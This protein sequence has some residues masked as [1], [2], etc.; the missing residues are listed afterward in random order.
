[1]TVLALA[2]GTGTAEGNRC[3]EGACGK[4]ST[5]IAS[6]TGAAAV[7]CC[8]CKPI[9]CVIHQQREATQHTHGERTTAANFG[10]GLRLGDTATPFYDHES[11]RPPLSTASPLPLQPLPPS[12]LSEDEARALK[13]EVASKLAEHRQRKPRA[14][15]MQPALP[16]E[17]MPSPRNRIARS[18][19]AQYSNRVSY[20]DYLQQGAE[21][22]IHQAEAEAEVA[23]RTA[24]AIVAAQQQLLNEIGNWNETT[25]V[26]TD[27]LFAMTAPEP[28]QRQR[29][30]R[31]TREPEQSPVQTQDPVLTAEAALSVAAKLLQQFPQ[32]PHEPA[33]LLPT[34]LIEFPRQLVAARKARPRLAEG[35]LR[36]EAD[37]DPDRAQL[38]IFEVEANSVS[39]EPIVESVL[40]EW[41]TIR[42][43]AT[44][45][46]L[47]LDHRGEEVSF[48]PPMQVAPRKL[49]LMAMLVDG[50]CIA[51]SFLLAVAAAAYASP[52]LPTGIPALIASAVALFALWLFY[53]VLF[54][55]ISDATPGMRY[56]RIG[57]CTFNDENPTRAAMLK[58]IG[59]RLLAGMP[60]GLGLLWACMDNE[61][62]GWHDRISRMYP[63]AY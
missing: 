53:Q 30:T 19:A 8:A 38:R 44:E 54:F 10:L 60:L 3:A 12:T 48:A 28:V 15:D 25:P 26:E 18:V 56:A 35:P 13:Q 63:R 39:T 1:M 24:D 2:S 32:E 37:A 16:L 11:E 31:S 14:A 17:G 50:C 55:S 20:R 7:T 41:H 36:E 6:A 47:E 52:I 21:S 62:L 40:P 43:D 45:H 49:R 29:T 61:G 33:E 5:G 58:R 46:D 4:L 27:D 51:T 34:N 9:P 59:A 42:L 23:R 22:A 57:L